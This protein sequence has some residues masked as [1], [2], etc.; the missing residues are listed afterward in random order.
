MRKTRL[1][2]NAT[3]GERLCIAEIADRAPSRMRGLMGR[4]ALPEG[5]GV[6][7]SPAPAIHTAFMRFPIDALFLDRELEVLEVVQALRPWRMA[8]K[9]HARSVLELPAGESSR[10]G[11]GVGDRLELREENRSD[12]GGEGSSFGRAARSSA[13]AIAADTAAPVLARRTERS[14]AHQRALAV[15]V[16]SPDRHFRT[17]MALLLAR[18][19]CSV[20]SATTAGQAGRLLDAEGIDV[21]VVDCSGAMADKAIAEIES[22]AAPIGVVL[23]SEDAE[24]DG[25]GEHVMPKW[26]PLESLIEALEA[27]GGRH[28]MEVSE[29]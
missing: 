28:A 25:R 6:L 17:V 12:P 7:L 29:R 27:A 5:E 3:R 19:N 9:R 26:G 23:V 10:L 4:R 20:L 13:R 14:V 18:R 1:I 24:G 16:V 21:A 8:S 11:V 15:L 22:R 2:F